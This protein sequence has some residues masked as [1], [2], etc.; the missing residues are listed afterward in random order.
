M[1]LNR[2]YL[3]IGK[4]LYSKAI[5]ADTGFFLALT[6][7]KDTNHQDVVRCLKL[8]SEH[9]LPMFVS[10]PTIYESHRRLLFDFGF[11]VAVRFIQEIYDGSINIIR[12][13]EE[14]E[15]EARRLIEKYEWLKLTLTDAVNMAIMI[16]LGIAVS[17]SFDR[18]YLE[19]GFIRIPPF[20]L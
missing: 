18:H 5:L 2:S 17:F 9:R 16:R 20:H 15:T 11:Q 14:D 10:V 6:N 1:N 7:P 8:I 4:S 19:V 12:T 3:S 13:I